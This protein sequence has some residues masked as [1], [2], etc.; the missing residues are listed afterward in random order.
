MCDIQLLNRHE[1]REMSITVVELELEEI[2]SMEM[3]IG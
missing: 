2:V 3:A 1:E